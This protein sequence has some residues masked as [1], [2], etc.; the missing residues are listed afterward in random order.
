MPKLLK[1]LHS[2]LPVSKQVCNQ[3]AEGGDNCPRQ[4]GPSFASLGPKELLHREVNPAASLYEDTYYDEAVR[5]AAQ[6]FV[7]RVQELVDRPDLD[8]AGL[9]NKSFSEDSPLLAFSDRRSLT[10]RD[11]HN[12]YRFLAAGLTHALRNVLSHHDNYGLSEI[13]AFEWL[14][15]I[16]AMHRRLDNVFQVPQERTDATRMIQ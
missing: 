16:S 9:I 14:C 11:E 5:K 2:A 6:R 3:D 4:R 15:F 12:G 7:N 13:S 8:G 10:E 1:P